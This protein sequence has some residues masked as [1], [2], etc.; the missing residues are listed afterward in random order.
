[1]QFSLFLSDCQQR[2]KKSL[3]KIGASYRNAHGIIIVYD[4]TN[5]KSFTN[6][7]QWMAEV[8]EFA[9]PELPKMLVQ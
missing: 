9:K 1:L 4:V 6:L 8:E 5:E 2:N 3:I 7:N